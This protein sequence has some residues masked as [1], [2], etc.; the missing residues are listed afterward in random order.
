MR[1]RHQDR[2]SGLQRGHRAHG[3][4][5]D[6]AVDLLGN[7]I[8]YTARLTE[9]PTPPSTPD[10][11][12]EPDSTPRPAL[13]NS[14]TYAAPPGVYSAITVGADH[15]CALTNDGEAIC[16]DIE[17]AETWDAS[18]GSYSFISAEGSDTCSITESGESACLSRGEDPWTPLG[19]GTPRYTAVVDDCGLTEAGAIECWGVWPGRWPDPPSEPLVAIGGLT[20][21]G[22]FGTT[23]YRRCALTV[24]GDIVCWGSDTLSRNPGVGESLETTWR[25]LASM[26]A[27]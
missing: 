20:K 21:I 15:A 25:W 12:V 10:E 24:T 22:G 19:E 26:A 5:L 14:P 8:L 9:P 1:G 11:P 6:P 17:S 13:P 3:S 2:P 23:F 16:W 7:A 4:G 18:P 27:A